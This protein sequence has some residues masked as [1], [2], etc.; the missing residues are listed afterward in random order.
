[1]AVSNRLIPNSEA[2]PVVETDVFNDF[3]SR[4]FALIAFGLGTRN[5]DPLFD[6]YLKLRANVY[7][8]QTGMLKEDALRIDGTELDKDD[9]RSS[10][11]LV[12]ENR[13]GSTAA[14]ACMRAIE[15]SEHNPAPLPIE[16]FFP[17][18]FEDGPAIPLSVEVS[19]FIS[20]LD[21]GSQQMV[22]I[23]ELFKSGLARLRKNKLGPVYGV[24]ETELIE[25]LVFF[26]APPVRVAEPRYVKE[27][28]DNNVGVEIDV[29][30]I[31]Q[32]IGPDVLDS[33]E[34]ADGSVRYWGHVR[35]SPRLVGTDG[36]KQFEEAT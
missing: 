8:Y 9:Y 33:T 2:T 23:L 31:S 36:G 25:S 30:A 7:V 16:G 13:I 15:K 12:L 29:G 20:C 3:S 19:R 17:E 34:T 35:Q 4:R 6:S 21:E 27:Y 11:F 22:A 26:G 14:V 28:S 1:M 18:L 5:G 10:H 32:Q 24:V